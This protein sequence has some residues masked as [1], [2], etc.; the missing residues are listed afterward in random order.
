MGGKGLLAVW[1]VEGDL[2][3]SFFEPGTMPGLSPSLILFNPFEA[4]V[5]IPTL[6][7]KKW[8]HVE[9]QWLLQR[10]TANQYGISQTFR[11]HT[12]SVKSVRGFCGGH[13]SV[14][15]P[16]P[17]LISPAAGDCNQSLTSWFPAEVS[18]VI[19]GCPGARHMGAVVSRPWL[20]GSSGETL[21]RLRKIGTMPL[22]WGRGVVSCLHYDSKGNIITFQSWKCIIFNSLLNAPW[23]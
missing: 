11:I 5:I 6:Y 8:S 20:P 23:I 16:S 15:S 18:P 3:S 17:D 2:M 21:S 10:P 9:T 7:V 13:G 4:R 1:A 14:S 12:L 19:M 22:G